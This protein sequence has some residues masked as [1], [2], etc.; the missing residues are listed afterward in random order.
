MN[1]NHFSGKSFRDAPQCPLNY[2]CFSKLLSLKP[3]KVHEEVSVK[4][5]ERCGPG[6]EMVSFCPH[7]TPFENWELIETTFIRSATVIDSR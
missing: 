3:L 1:L 7:V 6:M 4:V 5:S 2:V